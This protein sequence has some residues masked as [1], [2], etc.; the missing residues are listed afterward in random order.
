MATTFAPTTAHNIDATPAHLTVGDYE[1]EATARAARK[2]RMTVDEWLRY[3]S[4][5]E[6]REESRRASEVEMRQV[7]RYRGGA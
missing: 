2:A 5:L 6:E 3:T 7:P 1:L 4:R